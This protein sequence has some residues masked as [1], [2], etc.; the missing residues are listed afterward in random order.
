MKLTQQDMARLFEIDPRTLRNW[1]K[2]KPFLY[3]TI[4]KGLAFDEIVQTQVENLE[5]VK[6]LQKKYDNSK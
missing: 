2:D 6:E 3:K 4:M 1:R 5:K